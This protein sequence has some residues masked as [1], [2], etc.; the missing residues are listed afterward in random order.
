ML[1][2]RAMILAAGIGSRMGAL[3]AETPKPLLQVRGRPIVDYVVDRLVTAGVRQIVVNLHHH[4]ARLREHF[5]GRG[6]VDVTFSDE[7]EALL[8]TGGG[9]ARALD[10]LGPE[11]FFVVNG[12]VIWFDAARSSL[13]DMAKR[14]DDEAMDGLLLL[15]PTIF[16]VGYGGVGDFQMDQDGRLIRRPEN[17]V[18]PF[19]YSGVQ[20]LSPAL[21]A[22]CPDGVFSINMLYDR[23]IE[24]GRLYGW[25]HEGDWMELNNPDGLASA[26]A[27][28]SG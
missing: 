13:R 24:A 9:I 2:K 6:D 21:F 18:V 26:E 1:P 20:L 22:G 27:L 12:D 5:A 15:H 14:F 25:R 10:L 8:G 23:A 7:S 11:P 19:V 16:A 17:R 3:T 28:L 4:G